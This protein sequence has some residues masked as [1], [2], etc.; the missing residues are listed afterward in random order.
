[1]TCQ[2]A[3]LFTRKVGA[4]VHNLR[5]IAAFGVAR[6]LRKGGS[7]SSPH[8]FHGAIM[9]PDLPAPSPSSN[10]HFTG[11]Q[12]PC[13]ESLPLHSHTPTL[14]PRVVVAMPLAAARLR[15]ILMGV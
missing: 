8:A 10:Q 13:A 2:L 3:P 5:I 12:R 14:A 9:Y 1:M 4:D 6:L 7:A 11:A 15:S